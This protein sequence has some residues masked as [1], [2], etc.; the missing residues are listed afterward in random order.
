LEVEEVGK[1]ENAQP[2]DIRICYQ[3]QEINHS[4][5]SSLSERFACSVRRQ[6]LRAGLRRKMEEFAD[7]ER[8]K[9]GN[10]GEVLLEW[11]WEQLQAAGSIDRLLKF[12]IRSKDRT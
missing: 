5:I 7:K 10:V 1:V 8:R 11:A 3:S 6:N 9:L 4:R 12:K 2:T